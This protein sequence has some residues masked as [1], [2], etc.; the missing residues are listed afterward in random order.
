[1]ENSPQ[2]SL[3]IQIFLQC[4]MAIEQLCVHLLLQHAGTV[5]DVLLCDGCTGKDGCHVCHLS[6]SACT[7]A[8]TGIS[9]YFSL[10]ILL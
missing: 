7:V 6:Y 9:A 5:S 10:R 8:T 4:M 1:M 3:D 2:K